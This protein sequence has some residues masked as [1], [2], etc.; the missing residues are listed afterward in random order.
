MVDLVE[1]VAITHCGEGE[2]LKTRSFRRRRSQR[3]LCQPCPA[4][5]HKMFK[6]HSDSYCDKCESGRYQA[7]SGQKDCIGIKCSPGQWGPVEMTIAAVN[8]CHDCLEGR[9]S[10]NMGQESCQSCPGG[11]Y[12]SGVGASS[13]LGTQECP[14]GKWGKKFATSPSTCQQC[15]VGTYGDRSGLFECQS[16]PNGKYNLREG[17]S[18]CQPF[19]D[20]PR[21]NRVE[22]VEYTCVPIYPLDWYRLLVGVAWLTF[23]VNL[24]GLCYGDLSNAMVPCSVF[25]TFGVMGVAIWLTVPDPANIQ[26]GMK[27]WEY[28]VL[29][30]LFV[31]NLLGWAWGLLKKVRCR[32]SKEMVVADVQRGSQVVKGG[33]ITTV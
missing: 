27:D 21:W 8:A 30:V 28:G 13:C 16:C 4:G 22:R 10:P 24:L 5:R 29:M 1:G 3:V 6:E 26:D 19:P 25:T 32:T 11:Q 17:Q 2:Y 23:V 9:Y 18:A 14:A 33:S 15:P 7:E 31:Y 20:C 12:S